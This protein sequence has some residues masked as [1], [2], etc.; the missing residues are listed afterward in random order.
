M[1]REKSIAIICGGGPAPGINTVTSTVGIRFWVYIKDIRDF[2]P[3]ILI[4]RNLI[5][6]TQTGYLVEGALP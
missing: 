1:M 2:F 3:L 4:L 5:L 6:N